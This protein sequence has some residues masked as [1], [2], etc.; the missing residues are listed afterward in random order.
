[1]IVNSTTVDYS[2]I[3]CY[4]ICGG[5]SLHTYII[6]NCAVNYQIVYVYDDYENSHKQANTCHLSQPHHPLWYQSKLPPL[7]T[8]ASTIVQPK[9]ATSPKPNILCGVSQSWCLSQPCTLHCISQSCHLS[10]PQHLL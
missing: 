8:P 10:Q 9:A 1:L 6:N 2:A 7:P 3:W 5:W 4:Y